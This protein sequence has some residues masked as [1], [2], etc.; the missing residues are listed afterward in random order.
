MGPRCKASCSRGVSEE[1]TLRLTRTKRL[2]GE[3]S[4]F[5]SK[6]V[7][8]NMQRD[9]SDEVLRSF[10]DNSAEGGRPAVVRTRTVSGC[11]LI[12]LEEFVRL[13]IK[14]VPPEWKWAFSSAPL[15]EYWQFC[16]SCFWSPLCLCDWKL[17][18]GHIYSIK[19]RP[20]HPWRTSKDSQLL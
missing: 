12:N 19:A 20:W 7:G 8:E 13:P 17:L 14:S 18:Q 10:I 9:V 16:M 5:Q 2:K 11:K 3:Q 6:C 1:A 4:N 15:T